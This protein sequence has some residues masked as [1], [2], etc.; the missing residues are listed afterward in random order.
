M[1][2]LA[3]L[4]DLLFTF[5]VSFLFTACFFRFLRLNLLTALTLSALCGTLT[6]CAIAALL[7]A[8]HKKI[9]LKKS[10]AET[11]EK[12]LLHFALLSDEQLTDFF[13][14]YLTKTAS[15]AAA[16]QPPKN[17]TQNGKAAAQTTKPPAGQSVSIHTEYAPK[18]KGKL[19]IATQENDYALHF[20]FAP[21]TPDVVANLFRIKTDKQKILLC[22]TIDDQAAA[23][24]TRLNITYRT[25][26][27]VYAALKQAN[28]LPTSY[29]S[30]NKPKRKRRLTL[31][32]SKTNARRYLSSAAMI[33]LIAYITPFFYYYL[34]FGTA[35]LIVAVLVR[36]FGYD[37]QTQAQT[38]P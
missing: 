33:L 18:R 34:I 36:I 25:G 17:P 24:C 23:L 4:S 21:V 22:A 20:K 27:Q 12:L 35:L 14:A 1:K 19:R 7:S 10:D 16:K 11:K 5:L 29:I 13:L 3:F 6:T 38:Q 30:E 8:R 2:K 9:I 32:F 28:A 15:Q 31:W 26:E 37:P